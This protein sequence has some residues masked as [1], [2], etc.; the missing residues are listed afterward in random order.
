MQSKNWKRGIIMTVKSIP[1]RDQVPENLTWDLT[2]IFSDNQAFLAELDSVKEVTKTINQLSGI[3]S[4]SADDLLNVVKKVLNL[5]R[6]YENVYVYSHLSND[7]DTSN[8][9][10]QARMEQVEALGTKLSEATAWFDPEIINLGKAKI[11]N[12]IS[13]QPKLSEYNNEIDYLRYRLE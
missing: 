8:N 6:R 5:N 2:P 7:V 3:M 13:K 12:F 11:D 10:A 4:N 9:D 1:N